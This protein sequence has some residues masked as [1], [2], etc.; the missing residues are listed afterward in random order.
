M[1]RKWRSFVLPLRYLWSYNKTAT[2]T[3][4]TRTV[5][6]SSLVATRAETQD[7]EKRVVRSHSEESGE[8]A[9]TA[10]G[11]MQCGDQSHYFARGEMVR[12][13]GFF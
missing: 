12:T 4:T 13:N 2:A 1:A 3:T 11:T 7:Y 8:A 9:A 6:T 10:V 5:H